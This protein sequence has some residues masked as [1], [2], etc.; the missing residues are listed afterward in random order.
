MLFGGDVMACGGCAERAAAIREAAL[1]LARGDLAT[2][3]V[4]AEAVR[5]SAAHDAAVLKARA[6]ST[7]RRLAGR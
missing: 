1:A 3:R 6:A 7:L 4:Q 2:V 5:A